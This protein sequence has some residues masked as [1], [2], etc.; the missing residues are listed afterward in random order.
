MHLD[1][2]KFRTTF[3]GHEKFVFRQG[4]LKKGVDAVTENSAIF[5]DDQ[6]L[7]TLGVGKN[8]V[9]SIRHWCLAAGLLEETPEGG[10]SRPLGVTA[11]GEQLF[12]TPA[13]DAY[14]EDAGTIWLL[15]WQLAANRH[16][17]L[18]WHVIFSRFYEA[19]FTK[20]Q[21]SS[22][23]AKQIENMG[24]VTT[25]GTIDREIDCFLRT[26]IPAVRS[27]NSG[28][29]EESFDCPL[30]ELDLLR[31]SQ[32]D[33]LYSFNTGIKATLPVDVFGYGL[34]DF[35]R[36]AAKNRRT[37]HVDECVYKEGSPGQM[38]RMDENSVVE[39]IEILEEL[40]DGA[41]RL[42][43][44]AG[45]S[46]VYLPGPAEETWSTLPN[47]LLRNYYERR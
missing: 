1:E 35:L 5:A 21:L 45:L 40:T 6:A 12:R 41:I 14:L 34:I 8:M 38:F 24:V 33:N 42:Q 28:F 22:F 16:R 9:R 2:P 30:V 44:S 25:A 31:Y 15:H 7:V 43:D 27:R 29:S 17:T 20:R 13:W 36:S 3:G 46:Q 37:V 32:E 10:R 4:W 23:V 11:L 26:Y 47:R 19:E 39:Y 18:V